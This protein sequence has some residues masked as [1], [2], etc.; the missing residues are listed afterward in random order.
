MRG[1]LK[2]Q[3]G[4]T[5]VELLAVLFI[6][7]VSTAVVGV[8]LGRSLEKERLR[9]EVTGVRNLM[10]H[11]RDRA[12]TE[13]RPVTFF[14]QAE[15]GLYGLEGGRTLKVGRGLSFKEDAL[16]V[17]F[18]KGNSTGGEVLLSSP[19]GRQYRVQVDPVTGEAR[20]Q[21]L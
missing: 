2:R 14:V 11:A 3:A 4:F 19:E 13:R 9:Q 8:S 20:L 17:F 7:A 10:A 16:L 18:P 5:L 15:G 6:I 12:L 21:R 1:I